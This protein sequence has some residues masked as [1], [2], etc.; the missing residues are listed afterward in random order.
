[1][2]IFAGGIKVL[3]GQK[4]LV[5]ATQSIRFQFIILYIFRRIG[6]FSSDE[7][8]T[9]QRS[10]KDMDKTMRGVPTADAALNI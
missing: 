7:T 9:H 5:P 2:T 8:F 10:K 3:A 4:G 6:A 1:L